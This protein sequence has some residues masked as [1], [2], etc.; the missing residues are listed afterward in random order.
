MRKIVALVLFFLPLVNI[1]SQTITWDG[2]S[3]CLNI[4]NRIEIL[5][6]P[7]GSFTIEDVAEGVQRDNFKPSE[8]I[9][10]SFG[11]TNAYHWIKFKLD[12]ETQEAPW[13]ELAQPNITSAE[14]F[15]KDS[16]NKWQSYK[17]GFE[18]PLDEKFK[19]EHHQLFPL[20]GKDGQYYVKFLTITA[21]VPVKIWKER[22]LLRKA[23]T[24]KV[25]IGIF[26]GIL[27]FVILNSLMMGMSL[28]Q[29]MYFFYAFNVFLY[30]LDSAIVLDS[31]ILFLF[32][33][34]DMM[35]W[36][37]LV[38]TV[39]MAYSVFYAVVF[40]DIKKYLP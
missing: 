9:I 21:P 5:E 7:Q 39:H 22:A 29:N 28:G 6:D 8:Q 20:S 36:Y 18:V 14:F 13:L 33:G 12:N 24:Q 23:T 37:N 11:V 26:T 30:F 19:A 35:Y 31:Y 10:L 38:P 27:I 32:D 1:W 15:F 40:L 16:L 34:L 17:G 25:A 2:K 4:G 3:S